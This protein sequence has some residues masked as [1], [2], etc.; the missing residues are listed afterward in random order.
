MT[1]PKPILIIGSLAFDDLDMP[2]GHY[3][4]VLGGAAVYA[5]LAASVL[6][7]G[8]VRIVG[9]IGDDFP[10]THL[11]ELRS[12]GIDTAGVERASGQTF[13]WHGRYSDDLVSRTT[14]DTRLNVFA[15]FAPKIPAPYTDSPFV[16]L[17]NI[18]PK[19]QSLVLN[20]VRGPE[21][22]VADTMNFWIER[23]PNALAEVLARV[24]LLVINDEEARQLSGIHNLVKAAVDIRR[25]GPKALVIKRGEFGALLFDEG[26]A[27]FVPAF[28]LE[29]VVDPTGAGDSF[30]GGL[31]GYLSSRGEVTTATLRQA[32]FFAAA[33]GSFCVEGVGPSRLLA[34]GRAELSSR[35]EAFS[36]LVDHAKLELPVGF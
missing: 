30:A 31:L 22:V 9:V 28:P 5:A 19:L 20:Q 21:L 8:A 36:R 18:H 1:R 4:N 15:D 27:F 17:G 7:A 26:G 33:L 24:D 2:S 29:E 6:S 12:H 11:A 25:R 10:D 14:L 3:R 34:V 16:L 13:R 35:I 32:M 23:E